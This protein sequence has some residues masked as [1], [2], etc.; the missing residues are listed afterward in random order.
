MVE[1]EPADRYSESIALVRGADL[2]PGSYSLTLL[3][4][5][6]LVEPRSIELAR[7]RT[8]KY[9]LRVTREGNSIAV[10]WSADGQSFEQVL[11]RTVQSHSPLQ[12]I[13]I[14][15][16]S[17]AGGASFI[18][19]SLR[20]EGAHPDP[21]PKRPPVFAAERGVTAMPAADIVTALQAG[22]DIDLRG[23]TITGSFDLGQV[24]SPIA[25]LIRL[26]NCRFAGSF[27]VSSIV[28]L[29]GSL[30]CLNCEF[31]VAGLSNVEF[32]GP[33]SMVGCRSPVTRASSI[34][35][36]ALARISPAPSSAKGPSSA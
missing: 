21:V 19:R 33:L 26:E 13:V 2:D 3:L 27:I 28:S 8:D 16:S 1:G 15:S 18:L 34:R 23:C 25:S 32:D 5:E 35:I 29:T 36:S 11:E 7:T 10:S 12:T 20:L 17:F 22:R 31:G 9:C 14:N 30:S 4:H 6:G 24:A